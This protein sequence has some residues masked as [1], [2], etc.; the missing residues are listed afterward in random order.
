MLPQDIVVWFVDVAAAGVVP[1]E[2][3]GGSR[4]A[5]ELTA[6]AADDSAI[7]NQGVKIVVVAVGDSIAVGLNRCYIRLIP[8]ATVPLARS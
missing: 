2:C 6:G 1:F 5:V 7:A 4:A 3:D 8:T